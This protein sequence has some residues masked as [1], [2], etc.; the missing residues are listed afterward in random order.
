MQKVSLNEHVHDSVFLT[1][2]NQIFKAYPQQIFRTPIQI[3]KY[4]EAFLFYYN[5]FLYIKANQAIFSNLQ[6]TKVFLGIASFF[7][8]KISPP[9]LLFSIPFDR[10]YVTHKSIFTVGCS[11]RN[12]SASIG[13][14]DRWIRPVT[15]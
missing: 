7:L 15:I 1:A 8:T 12:K 4:I 11:L 14:I 5:Y 3:R 2:G 10:W 6:E 13:M 9:C